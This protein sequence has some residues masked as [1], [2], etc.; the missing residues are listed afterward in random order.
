MMREA[1]GHL[2]L[3]KLVTSTEEGSYNFVSVCLSVE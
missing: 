1:L 3:T 2:F